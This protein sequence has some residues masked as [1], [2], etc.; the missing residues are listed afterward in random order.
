MREQ[1]VSTGP[2]YD[3]EFLKYISNKTQSNLDS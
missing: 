2:K 3:S 1:A